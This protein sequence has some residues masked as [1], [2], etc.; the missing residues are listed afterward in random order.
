MFVWLCNCGQCQAYWVVSEFSLVVRF[1][2]LTSTKNVS[3]QVSPTPRASTGAGGF[4]ERCGHPS[5]HRT[6]SQRV[7]GLSFRKF[8]DGFC[9]FV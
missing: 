7:H 3:F 9:H 5:N 4:G 6:G 2:S 8:I 1:K